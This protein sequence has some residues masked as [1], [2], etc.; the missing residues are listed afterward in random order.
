[1]MPSPGGVLI[2]AADG[3][4]IGAVGISG[5]TGVNDEACALAR[6]GDGSDEGGEF[7]GAISQFAGAKTHAERPPCLA[8]GDMVAGKPCP[9]FA[10]K[11]NQMPARIQH[12]D[13][14]RRKIVFSPFGDGRVDNKVGLCQF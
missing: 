1:M 14:Q 3:D 11:G 12:S 7:G 2:V 13:R 4:V 9:V 8:K 6:H 5:D 10:L